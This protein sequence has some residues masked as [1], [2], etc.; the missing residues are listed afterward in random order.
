MYTVPSASM[1]TNTSGDQDDAVSELGAGVCRVVTPATTRHRYAEH[2]QAG[3]LDEVAAGKFY[4]GLHDSSE[5][6]SLILSGK[7]SKLNR[8]IRC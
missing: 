8:E 4:D 2:Q 3:G 7:Y 6:A 1:L 5:I